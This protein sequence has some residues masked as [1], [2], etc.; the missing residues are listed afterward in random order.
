[1]TSRRALVAAS[2]SLAAGLALAGVA[3][4]VLLYHPLAPPSPSGGGRFITDG[5]LVSAELFAMAVVGAAFLVLAAISALAGRT[6]LLF[7]AGLAATAL[8]PMVE[9]RYF[10]LFRAP[11]S[12]YLLL[13]A[14]AMLWATM[15]FCAPR[16]SRPSPARFANVAAT[17][18]PPR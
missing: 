16:R 14:L 9:V 7:V 15:A 1:M 10:S 6:W 11:L 18:P 5:T 2:A 8:A 13:A 4:D 17:W 3:A 12:A